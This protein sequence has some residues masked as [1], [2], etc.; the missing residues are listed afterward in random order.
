[1]AT[2]FG[3]GTAVSIFR[4]N[5]GP[6]STL[7]AIKV[8]GET[9]DRWFLRKVKRKN[10]YRSFKGIDCRPEAQCPSVELM[11]SWDKLDRT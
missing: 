9:R 5:R 7:G 4:P 1:M 2:S 8:K 3:G 11:G 6:S 10:K